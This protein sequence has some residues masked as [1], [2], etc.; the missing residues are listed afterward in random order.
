MGF[1]WKLCNI[2]DKFNFNW[3]G[4]SLKGNKLVISDE[5]ITADQVNDLIHSIYILSLGQFEIFEALICFSIRDS[6][7]SVLQTTFYMTC[8]S[9]TQEYVAA[10]A[11]GEIFGEKREELR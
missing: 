10:G 3:A 11:C 2:R 8:T 7:F 4:Y 6:P 1:Y 9:V 5:V